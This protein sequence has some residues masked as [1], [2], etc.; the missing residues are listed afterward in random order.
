MLSTR[1]GWVSR[2]TL[3]SKPSSAMNRIRTSTSRSSRSWALSHTKVSV[4]RMVAVC[5][6]VKAFGG[7]EAGVLTGRASSQVPSALYS[8]RTLTGSGVLSDSSNW[9]GTIPV[10]SGAFGGVADAITGASFPT[11]TPVR[12][13]GE[14]PPMTRSCMMTSPSYPSPVG[15]SAAKFQSTE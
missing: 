7:Q 13:S 2:G 6:L 10:D 15:R 4:A 3:R 5:R 12:S 9:I 14:I 11:S 8:T 1:K